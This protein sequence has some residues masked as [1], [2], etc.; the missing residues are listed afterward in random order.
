M[1]IEHPVHIL[2][3]DDRPENLLAL[4]SILGGL[5]HNLVM[6]H[7][8]EEALK[9]LLKQDFAVILLDV[10]MPGLDGFETA[11][12]IRGRPKSQHTPIIFLTA[13]DR[14]D[15]RIFKGYSVGA[16]DFLFKPFM[17]EILRSKVAVFVDLFRK[18]EQI[19]QHAIQLEQ[20][21]RARTADLTVANETLIAEI[22]ERKRAETALRYQLDLT[23]TI[24]DNTA[25]ALFMMDSD[26]RVT[27]MNPAAEFLFGWRED[28]LRGQILHERIHYQRPDGSPYPINECP[29]AAT[30]SG[31]QPLRNHQDTFLH[32]DGR[33]I[34]VY[35]SNAPILVDGKITG[36]VLA[37]SDYTERKR[38]EEERERLYRAAQE[39]ILARDEFLSI[40][41][42]ELKTPLTALQLQLQML[43]R[44]AQK[45]GLAKLSG[46]RLLSKL[47]MADQQTERLAG[48]IND[49]LDV[50]RIRTGRIEV[51]LE[52]VDLTQIV[53]DVVAR[54]E[55]QI[56]QSG[57]LVKLETHG[58]IIACW[59]RGRLEQ[60]VI[61]LLSNAIKYGPG[62]PIAIT[63][64][65]DETNA[66]LVVHDEGIGIETE[67]LERIFV[68]FERAVSANHYG[69]LGL[70]LYIVRQ[71]VEALGG[72]IR[73]RSEIGIG[74]TFTVTLP[75]TMNQ[76][77]LVGNEQ[78]SME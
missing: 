78:Q 55:E 33:V 37:V 47:Q 11:E 36:A 60:V 53:Q 76:P 7:S 48:L 52:E 44:T 15:A 59:D 71:I 20:R 14:S 32:K 29:L 4:E 31:G 9:R 49:L 8:G 64:R 6:A 50:A 69:G 62:K 21:V 42:H 57:C 25:E 5:G 70:G 65:S 45:G 68:R 12:L 40:A 17:P 74:S 16:V 46:E 3:V 61:N 63:V 34:P 39:A 13:L 23:S 54:F 35:C 77:M 41:S 72:S 56:A 24:T 1:Q 10:Q 27:F 2:M 58:P 67:H 38:A 22:G 66:E 19:Q 28:E 18:T 26:G 51:R 30:F 75:R 73:V 43:L